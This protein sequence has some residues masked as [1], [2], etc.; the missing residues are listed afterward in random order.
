MRITALI[1][2]AAIACLGV[3]PAAAASYKF[4]L[5]NLTNKDVTKISIPKGKIVGFKRIPASSSL[6]FTVEFPDGECWASRVRIKLSG[7][8]TSDHG[9]YNVCSNEGVTIYGR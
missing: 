1:T 2:L 5:H 7:G 8:E 6:T 9:R 4:T 3:G